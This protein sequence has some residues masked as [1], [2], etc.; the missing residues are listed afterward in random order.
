[1]YGA[2][3]MEWLTSEQDE[4]RSILSQLGRRH[5]TLPSNSRILLLRDP[6]P[7]LEWTT[8]MMIRLF[9]RDNSL[10]FE[11]AG[12]LGSSPQTGDL[13]SYDYVWTFEDGKLVEIKGRAGT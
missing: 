10:E 4:I 3:R 8:V 12:H 13:G 2:F 7:K 6:F 5:P 9:Y 11:Q 1:H